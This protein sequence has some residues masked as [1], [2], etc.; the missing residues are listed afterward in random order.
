MKEIELEKEIHTE[1][2]VYT[3]EGP[4]FF[5]AVSAFD[6][7]L[8]SIHKDPTFLIIRFAEVPFV[9][10]TGLSMLLD[11][12]KNLKERKVEVL[13]SDVNYEIRR[14]MYRLEY[15]KVLGRH[16]LWRTCASALHKAEHDLEIM[17]EVK[18]HKLDKNK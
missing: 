17:D 14:Q 9:D 3:I 5:G 10:L 1:I 13:L 4:L 7:A 6:G 2:M 8:N 15:Q 12:I 18:R 11:I 16:H